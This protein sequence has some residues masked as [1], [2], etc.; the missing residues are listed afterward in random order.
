MQDAGLKWQLTPVS[1]KNGG[2]VGSRTR[3]LNAFLN[4]FKHVYISSLKWASLRDIPVKE[5]PP[6]LSLLLFRRWVPSSDVGS[7]QIFLFSRFV[8]YR[9]AG[10]SVSVF[11]LGR[12]SY[13]KLALH[14]AVEFKDVVC[15]LYGRCEFVRICIYLFWTAFNAANRPTATCLDWVEH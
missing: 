2:G 7:G 10:V 12:L 5:H 6:P 8:S 14:E 11:D 9:S 3:V 4:H 1:R 13:S 15:F